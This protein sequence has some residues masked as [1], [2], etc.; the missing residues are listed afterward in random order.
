MAKTIEEIV[1]QEKELLNIKL[2]TKINKSRNIKKEQA[3]EILGVKESPLIRIALDRLF[4]EL[5]I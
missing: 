5:G 1:S 4:Q 2:N 3:M